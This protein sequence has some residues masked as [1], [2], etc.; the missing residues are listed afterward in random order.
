MTVEFDTVGFTIFD[1]ETLSTGFVVVV[2]DI[3]GIITAGETGTFVLVIAGILFVLAEIPVVVLPVLLAE[4][5]VVVLA[6]VLAV[7]LT[8]VIV[9]KIVLFLHSLVPSKYLKT[10][11]VVEQLTTQLLALII[12]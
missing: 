7:V 1:I 3:T 4:L 5:L 9:F 12:F 8:V 2:M 11:Y 6:V 10:V